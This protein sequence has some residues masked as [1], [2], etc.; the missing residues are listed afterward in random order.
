MSVMKQQPLIRQELAP[1]SPFSFSSLPT[2][3]DFEEDGQ[4]T[5]TIHRSNRSKIV[6]IKNRNNTG[7]SIAKIYNCYEKNAAKT[8]KKVKHYYNQYQ[9]VKY[10]GLNEYFRLYYDSAT[11]QLMI[12]QQ[13]YQQTLAQLI[14]THGPIRDESKVKEMMYGILSKLTRVHKYEY[15][16]CNIN[17]SHVMER[18][19]DH[20][21]TTEFISDGWLLIDFDSMQKHKT[22]GR[23]RGSVGWSAPEIDYDSKKNVYRYSSDIFSFGL[24]ILYIMIGHQPLEVPCNP[25]V[26]VGKSID[27]QFP[28]TREIM[29]REERKAKMKRD[30][31]YKHVMQYEKS[32]RNYLVKLVYKNTISLDLF[33]LLNEGLLVFDA[34]KRLNCEQIAQSKWFSDVKCKRKM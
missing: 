27:A 19:L 14:Q 10:S 8:K 15:V 2:P 6:L 26:K 22:K 29:A 4:I 13:C 21:Y 1:F 17:P 20:L 5:K 12:H 24:L 30:W 23:Y 11:Y 31:Y 9:V 18:K 16:H 32:L 33:E 25:T 7:Y 34:S 3:I 28:D